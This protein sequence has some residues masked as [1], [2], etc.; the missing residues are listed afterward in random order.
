MKDRLA[1]LWVWLRR[2]G[3]C[4]GF[5]IQSPA[6]YAFVR[7]VVNEHWPYYQYRVPAVLDT[8]LAMKKA[9]VWIELTNLIIPTV[10]DDMEMIRRMC[11]WLAEN[12]LADAPLHFSRFFPRYRMQELPPTPVHTLHAARQIA[13]DEGIR[14]VYLGNI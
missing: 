1:Y 4:R 5:G 9:G 13:L 14:H 10:N 6:D 11:R 7:Y 8:I 12:G 2:I 3:N